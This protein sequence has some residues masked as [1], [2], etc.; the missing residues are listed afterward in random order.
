MTEPE[1]R[2]LLAAFDGVGGLEAWIAGRR[3]KATPEGWTVTGELEG[4]RFGLAQV[5]GG[6]HVTATVPGGGAPAV[7]VVEE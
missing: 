7:W 6:L 3:W 5:P 1:A 4:W 2:A